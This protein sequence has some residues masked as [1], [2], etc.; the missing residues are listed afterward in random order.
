MTTAD[1]FLRVNQMYFPRLRF[2]GLTWISHFDLNIEW[3]EN[4][5]AR[6]QQ[7]FPVFLF[8]KRALSRRDWDIAEWVNE[9]GVVL[10]SIAREMRKFDLSHSSTAKQINKSICGRG[11]GWQ[12]SS[13]YLNTWRYRKSKERIKDDVPIFLAS[14]P[15]RL[16]LNSDIS[17]RFRILE[18]SRNS[19]ESPHEI[20]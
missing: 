18:R 5:D 3:K 20:R 6:S 4:R 17:G 14:N 19:D 16:S 1:Q 2:Q 11:I 9:G 7:T 12:I 8:R 15:Q 10:S 13:H